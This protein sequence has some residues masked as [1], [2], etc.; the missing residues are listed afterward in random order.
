MRRVALCLAAASVSPGV[1]R[2]SS[3]DTHSIPAQEQI[4]PRK[5]RRQA[6]A[7]ARRAHELH[8]DVALRRRHRVHRLAQEARRQDRDRLDR[9][10][11]RGTRAAVRHRLASADHDARRGARASNRPVAYIQA[12]I[13]AGEV[14]GKEAMQSMLRDLLFDK[15]KNVLDSIV[16]IVQP[17]YNADGNEKWGP[18]ERNRGAQNGP[19]LV[20]TRQNA[21]ELESESRLHRRRRARDAAARSRCSTSGIRICSWIST[22]PTAAFTATR[23]PTRRRSRRP[24]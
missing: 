15:K 17:I 14:E 2:R 24:R 5:L 11:D 19:E 23:S 7:H 22:R 8:R 1:C 6:A 4:Q 21:S 18:Q 16:L 9:Q 12:N 13:H 3:V 20:G 10:D